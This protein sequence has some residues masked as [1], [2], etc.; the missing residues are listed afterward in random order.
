MKVTN[1]NEKLLAAMGIQVWYA[2]EAVAR[3]AVA[4]EE[5]AHPEVAREV[6]DGGADERREAT[7]VPAITSQEPIP[8]PTRVS[9]DANLSLD[10]NDDVQARGQDALPQ[11]QTVAIATPVEVETDVVPV[12]YFW[13]RGGSGLLLLPP[14]GNYDEQLLKD[15]VAAM[16]WRANGE[17]GKVENGHFRWPQLTSTSGTPERAI[18]AFI[19][20]FAPTETKWV[21]VT[22]KLLTELSPYLTFTIDID[23]LPDA[24]HQA[25]EKKRLWQ[26]LGK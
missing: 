22:E 17:V 9:T 12:E 13:W 1:R 20:K 8:G 24:L 7:N 25:D 5:V 14:P 26:I 18:A 15:I 10:L 23:T 11:P 16:D 2:R 19:D 4:P 6:V 3:E 21:M